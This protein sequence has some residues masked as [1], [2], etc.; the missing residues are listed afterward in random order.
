[1]RYNAYFTKQDRQNLLDKLNAM[2]NS[3]SFDW[4]RIKKAGEN[5]L[6]TLVGILER[7]AQQVN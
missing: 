1:M 5:D 6:V 2:P 7:K 4:D 3:D